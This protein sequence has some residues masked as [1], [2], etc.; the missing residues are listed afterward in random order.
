MCFWTILVIQL[1]LLLTILGGQ[2]KKWLGLW[3]SGLTEDRG[4][5]RECFIERLMVEHIGGRAGGAVSGCTACSGAGW[6]TVLKGQGPTVS[7][8]IMHTGYLLPHKLVDKE[9]VGEKIVSKA[10]MQSLTHR[11]PEDNQVHLQ[12]LLWPK[13]KSSVLSSKSLPVL[14]PVWT[15]LSEV[16]LGVSLG[17]RR[18]STSQCL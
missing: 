10:K 13:A 7:E 2:G 18:P 8:F 4:E 1:H 14:I 9:I 16:Q 12:G 15:L 6:P 17:E 3:K 5:A 11:L